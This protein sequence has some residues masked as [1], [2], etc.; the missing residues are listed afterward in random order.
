MKKI[1]TVI[2]AYLTIIHVNAQTSYYVDGTNGNDNYTGTSIAQAWKTV[3]YAFENATAGSTV[4]IKGGTYNENLNASV[5]GTTGNP[6]TYR[7]YQNETVIIDGTGTSGTDMLYIEDQ[8]YIIIENI[9]IQNK[10]A[11]YATGVTVS[12]TATGKVSNIILRNLKIS[13]IN[14]TSNASAT[15]TSNDNSNPMLITGAGTSQANAI[16]N[17]L[18]DSCEVF[19]NITGFSESISLDG[20]VDSFIVSHNHVHDNLNIGID[21]AGNY[22]V[23][24]NATLDHARHGRCFL[25]TCFNNVSSYATSGGIYVDG[26]EN[27][28]I[29][30]NTSYGNGWGI[31]IG[32]E[33]N[34]STSNIIV[35]DNV[36]YNNKEAGL[37]IGGYDAATTG[38][39]L[40]TL[41]TNN[42]FL[43]DD[44]SNSGMG[45]IY[46][47]KMSNCKIQNNIF[48]TNAQNILISKDNITPFSANS[49]NYNCWYTPNNNNNSIQV[50]WGTSTYTTFANYV[51][52]TGMDANSLYVDPQLTSNNVS[53]PDFHILITSGC[54]DKGDPTYTAATNETDYFGGIRVVNSKVDIGANEYPTPA[55]INET[56]NNNEIGIFPD[57]A[58]DRINIKT[59]VKAEVE[60]FNS[61]GRLIKCIN[62]DNILT[63]VDIFNLPRGMY[64]VK[65]I[66]DKGIEVKKF[67]KK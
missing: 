35:R 1:I 39:V 37:A 31:E 57:P 62:A 13:G 32:C 45:E 21:M 2:I 55:A 28:I 66:T 5:S 54:I 41:V 36:F 25:N 19:N 53:S 9:T 38:Q 67:I 64:V 16:K 14:W 6:I 4:Y 44:Y 24:S 58:S 34:G 59:P 12:S 15:P 3:Q 46:I 10:V 7:N 51:A 8:S 47:T 50:I 20:N 29:E 63:C 65:V 33:Q 61:E 43:K 26:G 11:A 56:E 48:Y 27:I 42:T 23:S 52:Q 40:N 17:I 30:R 18:I 60:I 22:A 49:I